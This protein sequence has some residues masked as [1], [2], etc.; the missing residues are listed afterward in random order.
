MFR[1]GGSANNGIMSMAAP[2]KNYQDGTE[3]EKQFKKNYLFLKELLDQ[4]LVLEVI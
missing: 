1:I 4:D 3:Y 2:R